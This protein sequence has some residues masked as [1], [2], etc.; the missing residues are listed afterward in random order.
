MQKLLV[1]VFTTIVALHLQAQQKCSSSA[2]MNKELSEDI[3]LAKRME[4]IEAFTRQFIAK[5]SD[6]Q[7]TAGTARVILIPVVF[8]IIYHTQEENI[9]AERIID[10][11]NALNKDFRR[12]NADSVN[13][14][15]AFLPV[16]AD[17]E[18]EFHLATSDPSGK[19]TDGIIRKYS[20]LKFW[21]SDDKVKFSSTYGDDAWDADSYLNIW[22]CNL[23]DA[24]GY[25][26]LPGTDASK[27]GIVVSYTTITN[28]ATKIGI[29]GRTMTHEIG[30]WLN[31]RHLWGDTY[32]GNDFVDDTPQQSTYTPGC[33]SGIRR[34][35]GNNQA[36]DMYMNYMDFTDDAC[37][38]LF[39]KGQKQ[40]AR[41]LFELGGYRYSILSSKAFTNTSRVEASEIPDFYP[42][43][44]EAKIYPNPATT[45]LN[46]YLEYDERWMGK[47]II[48]MD[49]T[50]K[51]MMKKNITAS[52]Q[53]I[54]ISRLS[55][56][57]YFIRAEKDNENIL[58]KFI[59]L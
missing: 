27:D 40:R 38:N 36:G 17:M 23:V 53:Q 3:G 51:L 20:P 37:M 21:A 57:V 47:E 7:R 14:P 12:K 48:I 39:T 56:G 6:N 32:C 2:Y 22:V 33:P 11:L 46:I 16:A 8:H 52:V 59:K 45:N 42:K 54:D 10:E 19:N 44:L 5:K 30:H 1:I 43:W 49:M 31:L 18:I 26:S 58:K 35:C 29:N 50:G 28:T 24:L 9:K 13:T 25:S 41:A 34:T 4:D 15:Q 55:P